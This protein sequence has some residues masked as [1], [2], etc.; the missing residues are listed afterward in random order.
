MLDIFDGLLRW[1][2]D[3]YSG[4]VEQSSD[5]EFGSWYPAAV[6]REL[7]LGTRWALRADACAVND[8]PNS[9]VFF[10]AVLGVVDRDGRPTGCQTRLVLSGTFEGIARPYADLDLGDRITVLDPVVDSQRMMRV[11]SIGV[12]AVAGAPILYTVSLSI[13]NPPAGQRA[14]ETGVG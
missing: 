9:T 4:D 8:R 12:R 14:S 1:M 2:L 6:C 3:M 10:T 11:E 7:A 5:P 13:W